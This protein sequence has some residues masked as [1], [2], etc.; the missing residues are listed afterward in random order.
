MEHGLYIAERTQKT[1]YIVRCLWVEP[2]EVLLYEVEPL[3]VEPIDIVR[4][5]WA[6][7]L[8]LVQMTMLYFSPVLL[9]GL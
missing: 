2:C 4:C 7:V 3:R 9:L 1:V 5:L 6:G 8:N